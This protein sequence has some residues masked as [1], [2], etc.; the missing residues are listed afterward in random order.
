MADKKQLKLGVNK[1]DL[2]ITEQPPLCKQHA[3]E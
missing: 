1:R 3:K 2:S